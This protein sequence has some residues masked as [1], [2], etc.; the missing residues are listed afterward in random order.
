[1]TYIVYKK[2]FLIGF[3]VT[4]SL[5][6]FSY[7]LRWQGKT[8]NKK[9][10]QFPLQFQLHNSLFRSPS[11]AILKAYLLKSLTSPQSFTDL[12]DFFDRIL[13]TPRN[14]EEHIA[15]MHSI[16]QAASQ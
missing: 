11:L 6:I 9:I 8:K 16:L 2:L 3:S 13:S 5:H 4:L 15:P 1:M 12:H 10:H 14:T 7:P